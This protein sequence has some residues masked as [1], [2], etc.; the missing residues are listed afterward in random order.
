MFN[1]KW[2]RVGLV[3][4]LSLALIA[5]GCGGNDE[6]A[7]TNTE[8]S[9]SEQM[10]YTITG[11]E[12]G[13]G[14]SETNEEVIASY[15]NLDGWKQE[16]SSAAAMLSAL[17]AAISNE[18]P[19]IVAAWSPHYMFAK[20]DLKYLEDPQGIFGGEETVI[21]IARNGLKEDMPE[22]YTILDRISWETSDVEQS[23]LA[24]QEKEFEEVAQEW[25]D[26]NKETV[27]QWT[28][29]VDAVN[30]TSIELV[31]A[32]WD[33]ERF[34]T[35]V[36]TL[37]LE[38]QGFTVTTTPVDPAVLFKSI[39]TGDADASLSPWMP[40]SQAGLYEQY[41]GE[42][43]DLGPNIEGGKVGLAVPKY[44]DIDSLED[45]EPKK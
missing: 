43:E 45:L 30:G 4:G 8:T 7:N 16:L 44:V 13:A 36:A 34:I 12:P 39:A 6:N 32:P 20:W 26:E 18:E 11:I 42:F 29:G 22:A 37:V 9:V 3:A 21:T 24:A 17:D 38:Q 28:K 27:A 1:F 23:L 14:Q 31:Y 40:V 41:E 10:N 25:I 2:K 33:T 19:I 5:A 35:S 15:D